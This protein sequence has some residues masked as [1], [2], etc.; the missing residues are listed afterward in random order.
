MTWIIQTKQN[1][2]RFWHTRTE[3]YATFA[4]AQREGQKLAGTRDVR[5]KNTETG[6]IVPRFPGQVV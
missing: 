4:E 5:Y 3:V 2:S 6:K 1:D